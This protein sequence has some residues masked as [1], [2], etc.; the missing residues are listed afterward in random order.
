[1]A[2]GTTTTVRLTFVA[3]GVQD[4]SP[5]DLL[6]TPMVHPVEAST[7]TLDHCAS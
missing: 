5:L 1:M 7:E 4:E 6:T 3:D 2:F